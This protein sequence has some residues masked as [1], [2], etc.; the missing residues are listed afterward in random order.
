[1]PR[2]RRDGGHP[3][4]QRRQTPFPVP[5][6]GGDERIVE[7]CARKAPAGSSVQ[8]AERI[9]RGKRIE[10]GK[11]VGPPEIHRKS[12]TGRARRPPGTSSTVRARAAPT[13][14][15][16]RAAGAGAAPV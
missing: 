14:S 2:G 13:I 4:G 3:I 5:G 11:T 10:P 15:R 9:R 6:G 16:Y 12:I 1:D 7:G 8:R